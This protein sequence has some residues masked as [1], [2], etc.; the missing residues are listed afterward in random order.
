MARE[1]TEE[2]T[3]RLLGCAYTVHKELGPGL[4]ETIYEKALE[5]ELKANGFEVAHQVSVPVR[6][7]GMS[8]CDNLKLDLL[9][10]N[11]VILELKSVEELAPVAFKQLMTYLRLTGCR[12]G[13]LINFNVDYLKHGIHRVVNN[14]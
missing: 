1:I 3:Y 7:K 5:L 2:Y 12:L 10:D 13:Y 11:Q 8:I 9:I 4:L 6:Y 14:F